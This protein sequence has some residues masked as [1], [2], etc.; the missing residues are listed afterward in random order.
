MREEFSHWGVPK[1]YASL[2]WYECQRCN[3]LYD[4]KYVSETDEGCDNFKDCPFCNKSNIVSIS[5]CIDGECHIVD[6]EIES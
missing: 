6:E 3:Q 5:W 4:F 2:R 1:H